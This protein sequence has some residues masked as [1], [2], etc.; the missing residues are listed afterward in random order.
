MCVL[1]RARLDVKS[2]FLFTRIF[3]DTLARIVKLCYGRKGGKLSDRIVPMLKD[4][5]CVK[6]WKKLDYN[7]YKGLKNRMVWIDNFVKTRVEIVH[8]LGSMRSTQ[9]KDGK[10]GFDIKGLRTNPSWGT[11]TVK[12][13]TDYMDNTLHNLSEVLLY[14]CNKFQSLNP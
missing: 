3:L 4:E 10:F 6:V 7:F 1:S 2:F 12:S 13:V 5:E 11:H 9:T 8:Y 14:I